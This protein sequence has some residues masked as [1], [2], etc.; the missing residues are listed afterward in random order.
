MP[1][2]EDYHATLG[3]SPDASQNEI[4]KAYR[5]LSLQHHPDRCDD[6]D[7]V[8]KFKAIEHAYEMLVEPERHKPKAAFH[9]VWSLFL[10]VRSQPRGH[11]RD[12]PTFGNNWAPPALAVAT[13]GWLLLVCVLGLTAM[14]PI[15][16]I[17]H[18]APVDDT[19]DFS[20]LYVVGAVATGFYVVIVLIVLVNWPQK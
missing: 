16:E 9:T 20:P 5:E 8:T 18:D 10:T 19:F 6:P 7:A 13:I 15:S 3:V 12:M 11:H 14:P 17:V 2:T 1:T 4:K